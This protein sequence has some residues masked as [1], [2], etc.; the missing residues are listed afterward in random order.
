MK[1][2]IASIVFAVGVLAALPVYAQPVAS[3]CP[4]GISNPLQTLEGAWTYSADGVFPP[5]QQYASAGTFLASIGTDKAGNPKGLLAIT[6]TTSRN[7]Q[8]IR[9][10]SDAGSYQ[11]SPDCS[12]GTLTLNLSTRPIAFD[13]WYVAGGNEIR[14]VSI[15]QGASV[16]G[17]AGGTTVFAVD[18]YK[19]CVTAAKQ[20]FNA[21]VNGPGVVCTVDFVSDVLD[22]SLARLGL[23]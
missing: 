1:C 15:T 4:A 10:E 20:K 14:F 3:S 23:K 13:F 2:S 17:S 22:C 11:V 5:T 7:G 9:Q 18:K 19:R 6:Q 16:Q 21:C 12:G 8:I